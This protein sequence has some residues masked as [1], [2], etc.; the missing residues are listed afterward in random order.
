MKK[1]LLSILLAAAGAGTLSAQTPVEVKRVGLDSL[2]NFLRTEFHQEI[3]YVK[4]AAEQ[5]TFSVSAPR[6][7]FPD[8]AFDALR[9]KG[10]TISSYGTVRFIL[11]GKTVYTSLPAGYF[12]AGQ[13]LGDDSGLQRYLAEQNA[14]VTFQ[15]KV[16]EIDRKS[17]V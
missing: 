17:V 1:I 10:Y 11:H 4:D 5:S 9:E 12:D 3:Y 6:T 8:A 16:Y 7:Q 14:V 15:N 2:V 13:K